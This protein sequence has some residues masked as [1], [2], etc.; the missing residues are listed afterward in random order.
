MER[1]KSGNIRLLSVGRGVAR[2]IG[3]VGQTVE[4]SAELI[5]VREGERGQLASKE[6]E[7]G[8]KRYGC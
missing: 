7:D 8:R 1:E 6:S 5:C 2:E 3:D 4:V